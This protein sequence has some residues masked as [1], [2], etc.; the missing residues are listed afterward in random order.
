MGGRAEQALQDT[1]GLGF[2]AIACKPEADQRV[3]VGPHRAVVIR[4]GI[5]AGFAMSN[6]ADAPSAER[7]ATHQRV[8]SATCTL[9]IRDA[10]E[11]CVPGVRGT[12]A[13]GPLSA[14]ERK[15]IRTD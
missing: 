11:Q 8:S 6:R 15:C 4:H 13:S 14:I 3:V 12:N 5:V 2:E 7:L 9:R 1:S 10:C